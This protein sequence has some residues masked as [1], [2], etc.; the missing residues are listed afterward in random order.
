MSLVA[1]KLN[2]KSTERLLFVAQEIHDKMEQNITLFPTPTVA[3]P[4][5][6]LAIDALTAAQ[7]DTITGGTIQTVIRNERRATLEDLL[8]S[9]AGYVNGQS[10]RRREIAA[11]S[12]M[13]LKQLGPRHIDFLEEPVELKSA[14]VGAGMVS[15]R[16]KPVKHTKQYEIEY[17]LEPISE[18]AWKKTPLMSAANAVVNGL[19]RKED[20]W[21]R[22][23]AT[24]SKG[25]VSAWS[26]PSKVLVS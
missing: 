4:D 21:F 15:L 19:S 8:R 6:Q 14:A 10:V 20:Y 2:R 24:G 17:C 25:I 23:R 26:S 3:M 16:W 7:Q 5:L 13:P 12:G 9:L 11:L 18:A 22:V 1:L